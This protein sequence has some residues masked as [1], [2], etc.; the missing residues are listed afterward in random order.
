[1]NKPEL[2][3]EMGYDSVN[4]FM[5]SLVHPTT[6]P[7]TGTVSFAASGLAYYFEQYVGIAPAVGI[8]IFVLFLIE[9]ITG[10]KASK[11]ENVK[12]SS[13]KFSSGI[14]KMG[15]YILVIASVHTFAQNITPK[16]LF[17]WDFNI[18]EWLHYFFLNFIILQMIVSNL[19]NFERLGWDDMI[20]AIKKI[21]SFIGIKSK[22]K[23]KE[24][25]SQ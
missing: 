1:M 21:N 6:L 19:E 24:G 14:F 7:V 11:K 23:P 10:I 8:W 22:K 16:P 17:G 13:K 3:K 4:A 2:M 15:I 18:Y 25:D 9:M 12:F 5:D 20:P